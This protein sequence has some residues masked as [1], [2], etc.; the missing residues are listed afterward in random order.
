MAYLK[1]AVWASLK[2]ANIDPLE[3]LTLEDQEEYTSESDNDDGETETSK[4]EE[5]PADSEEGIIGQ[6]NTEDISAQENTHP[7]LPE[8]PLQRS[9]STRKS[10]VSQ[11]AVPLLPFSVL[12][13]DKYSLESET[14]PIGRKFPWGFA[15]PYDPDHCDFQKLKDLVFSDWRSELRE[16]SRVIWYERWRTSRLN[17]HDAVTSTKQKAFGGRTG[18]DFG[19]RT[20]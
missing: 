17:R 8:S 1:K 14:E 9:E 5:A 2:Q 19:R 4:A 15:D 20:R 6:E 16:A 18:P 10:T 11:A 3:I 12:S 7:K 13:P